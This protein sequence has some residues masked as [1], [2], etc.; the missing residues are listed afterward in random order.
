MA[1]KVKVVVPEVEEVKPVQHGDDI[2]FHLDRD[3]N[4]PRLVSTDRPLPSLND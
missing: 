3:P 4:D 1:K 2:E